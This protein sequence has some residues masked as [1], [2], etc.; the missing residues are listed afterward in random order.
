MKKFLALALSVCLTAAV[1]I[2]CG[3]TPAPAPSQAAS[4][5]STPAAA[6]AAGLQ[7][8][9]GPVE[10]SLSWWG[11]DAR[12]EATQKAVDAF[13]TKYPNITVK[14]NYGAWT[15][16]EDTMS[17]ALYAGTAQDVDQVNWNWIFNYDNDG[18]TFV[19]LNTLSDYIDLTQFNEAALAQCTVNGRLTAIPVA[20]TGRIFYWNQTTF[21]EAGIATP[22]TFDELLAAGETFKTKLGEEYYPLAMNQLDRMI[23]MVWAL[24]CEYGKDWVVDG[25]LNYSQAEIEDG[26]ALI[27]QLEEAHVIPTMEK[28][29][30]DGAESFDKNPKWMEGKYAGIFEWDSSATKMQA[31]LNEGQEFVVGE[32]L[33][34]FGDY[35]GGF[36]KVSLGF[37]IAESAEYPVES[38]MLINFLLNEEEGVKLMASERGIPLSKVALQ[39]CTDNDLLNPIV[40]EANGKVLAWCEYNLDPTFEDAKLKSTD[41]VYYDVMDGLSYGDYDLA[42]AASILIEGIEATLAAA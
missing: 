1:V 24:E 26:L 14:T 13:T 10:L 38:A 2:G 39:I 42:E 5:A 8:A 17:T 12:H 4:A 28:V 30:G 16:W 37:S 36:T 29:L 15:G 27:S 25:K 35:K 32:F 18:K 22:T 33:T 19:D 7:P 21:D 11:G 40:A 9:D 34:G 20:M 31:A 41:G 6:S 3:S 23:F